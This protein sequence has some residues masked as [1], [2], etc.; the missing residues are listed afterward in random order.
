MKEERKPEYPEKTPGN[1]LQKMPHTKARRFKPQ[2]RL[3]PAQQHSWQARKADVLTVTPHVA[4][5]RVNIHLQ[6]SKN[7]LP[8]L[9]VLLSPRGAVGHT[10][11]SAEG[12]GKL[13][14]HNNNW[15]QRHYSR[16]V[17]ISSQREL[18]LTRTL[19]W[20]GRNRVQITCNTSSAYHVQ[21]SCY[22]PLGTKGQLSY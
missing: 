5:L 22:V 17:T 1:K 21:V 10:L 6:T 3:K 7:H 4:P 13:A 15:I 18:S 2:A 12:A 19:K 20:P 9:H 8:T 16:F 11:A 14:T